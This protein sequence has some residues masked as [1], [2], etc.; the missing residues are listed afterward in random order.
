MN[1]STQPVKRGFTLI[2]LLI[3]IAIIAILASI[4]FP[5]FGRARENARRSSCQSNLKQLG[6][7]VAQYSQDY[8]ELFPANNAGY[9]P[10]G[11]IANGPTASWDI[12]IQPYVK[13]TQ[14]IT[15]PSDSNSVSLNV[16]GFGLMKRSYA[17]PDY[18][19]NDVQ[20]WRGTN[21]STVKSPSLTLLLIERIN[22]QANAQGGWGEYGFAY[23]TDFVATNEGDSFGEASPTGVGR[24]LGTSNFLYVDGHVKAQI[25][26][27]ANH[28]VASHPSNNGALTYLSN[29]NTGNPNGWD[30]LPQ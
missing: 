13:S 21:Q 14:I 28:R 26:S 12:V 2:E 16:Q 5:V 30:D 29:N 18:L 8:D 6:L 9:T 23:D 17:M 15:C 11:G 20:W 27:K 7:G 3:V 24:H 4:L 10:Y 22:K 1:L 19:N 25:M